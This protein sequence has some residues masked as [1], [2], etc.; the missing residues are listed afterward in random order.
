M[1]KKV[2]V[3]HVA[4]HTGVP[5][6]S[7]RRW[8]KVSVDRLGRSGRKPLYLSEFDKKVLD[9]I[10]KNQYYLDAMV[11]IDEADLFFDLTPNLRS[12]SKYSIYTSILTLWGKGDVLITAARSEKQRL[13]TLIGVTA[14]S[15]ILL[16]FA[17]VKRKKISEETVL[18][19]FLLLH[20]LKNK[21]FSLLDLLN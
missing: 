6:S 4:S 9:L 13:A 10:E 18:G 14:G 2:G 12:S 15:G 7:V 3:S 5:E 16:L 17:I 1:S 21:N 11:N 8:R 20:T 19:L